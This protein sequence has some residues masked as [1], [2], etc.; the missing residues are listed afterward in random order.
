MSCFKKDRF[1]IIAS[2]KLLEGFMAQAG[3]NISLHK[4]RGNAEFKITLGH[5]SALGE[6]RGLEVGART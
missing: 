1:L 5:L 6:I 2:Y 4:W 3:F